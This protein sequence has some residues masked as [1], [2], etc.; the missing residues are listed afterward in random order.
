MRP[1]SP[2]ACSDLSANVVQRRT[3]TKPLEL[4]CRH[5]VAHG[6]LQRL[7]V[8]AHHTE[9]D[10]G[11]GPAFQEISETNRLDGIACA[12]AGVVD[13]VNEPER[14]N[15]L[16]L[17]R[18]PIVSLVRVRRIC[19]WKTYFEVGLMDSGKGPSDN[20][21]TSVKPRLESGMLSRTAFTVVVVDD[22]GP[23][24]LARFETLGDVG[25]SVR[26]RLPRCMVV[27]ECNVYLSRLVVHS[28]PRR[29]YYRRN[30]S[31]EEHKQ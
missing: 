23:W 26:L 4:V 11:V 13:L 18:V 9:V 27:V 22:E 7:A 2:R 29:Q 3:R 6:N 8:L 30:R 14:Q 12:N 25:D 31:Q 24:L 21:S 1:L 10:N 5:R 28:L 20:R 17:H 19:K 15:A 16:F